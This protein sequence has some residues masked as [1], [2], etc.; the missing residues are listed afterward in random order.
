MVFQLLGLIIFLFLSSTIQL[1]KALQLRTQVVDDSDSAIS[2]TF[3]TVDDQPGQWITMDAT[4]QATVC[5]AVDCEGVLDTTQVY[6]GTWH[7]GHG[8]VTLSYTFNGTGV[9]AYFV[10]SNKSRASANIT[11][12]VDGQQLQAVAGQLEASA[13]PFAY[14][15]Q[16]F[17]VSGLSDQQHHLVISQTGDSSV[18]LFDYLTYNEVLAEVDGSDNLSTATAVALQA[19]AEPVDPLRVP[20]SHGAARI[21]VDKMG[22][23]A[24]SALIGTFL[25]VVIVE[26]VFRLRKRRR[27]AGST[28][29]IST[30]SS[31][32]NSKYEVDKEAQISP[33]ISYRHRSVP[34]LS[35]EEPTAAIVQNDASSPESTAGDHSDESVVTHQAELSN[36]RSR[37]RSAVST[38]VAAFTPCQITS[39]SRIELRTALAALIHAGQQPPQGVQ[40]NTRADP[41]GER[42]D[43]DLPCAPE[44]SFGQL[45]SL[46]D[47]NMLSSKSPSLR[48]VSSLSSSNFRPPSVPPTAPLRL[49]RPLDLNPP[50]S[51]PR[52]TFE[53]R[54]H[55]RPDTTMDPEVLHRQIQALLWNAPTL[56]SRAPTPADPPPYVSR[57]SSLRTSTASRRTM[58]LMGNE[59]PLPPLPPFPEKIGLRV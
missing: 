1:S 52:F 32:D 47:S 49:P 4:Q 24:A 6:Q 26:V 10:T 54:T 46:R 59:P 8:S 2:Y 41:S 11:F 23:A 45:S 19:T 7:E 34:I 48:S 29:D 9:A 5:A 35:S 42:L 16:A 55:R 57:P 38:V 12:L 58:T 18:L 40:Y 33:A 21:T 25:L 22:A 17:S 43:V 37:F 53:Q 39:F 44:A 51:L 36:R 27:L 3:G 30:S 20:A 28:S 13:E 50:P 14:N 15:V 56:P 31:N